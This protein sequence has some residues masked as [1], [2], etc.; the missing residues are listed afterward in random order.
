MDVTH[1]K[2][3]RIDD[4]AAFISLFLFLFVFFV[5]LLLLFFIHDLSLFTKLPR[6]CV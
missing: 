5:L 2:I 3:L 1:P 4:A 6:S